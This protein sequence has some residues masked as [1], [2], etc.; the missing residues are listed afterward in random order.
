MQHV[1]IRLDDGTFDKL[2]DLKQI[3]NESD[4]RIKDYDPY[5]TS[6]ILRLCIGMIWEME[7]KLPKRDS[8][9]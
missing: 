7:M 1:S 4:S 5:T 2:M 8:V 6:D 9:Q 3:W